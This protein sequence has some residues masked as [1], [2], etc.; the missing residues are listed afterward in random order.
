MSTIPPNK[1][2]HDEQEA[3]SSDD[4]FDSPNISH[5]TLEHD[6]EHWKWIENEDDLVDDQLSSISSSSTSMN[7]MTQHMDRFTPVETK[8]PPAS[9]I[10]RQNTKTAKSS[11]KSNTSATTDHKKKRDKIQAMYNRVYHQN[12][13]K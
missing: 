7:N 11:T 13:K 9:S 2:T 4:T 8:D 6:D 1:G 10:S 3:N 5:K 12:S